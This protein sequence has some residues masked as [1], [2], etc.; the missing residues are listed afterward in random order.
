MKAFGL[1]PMDIH[2]NNKIWISTKALRCVST[3]VT[4]Q[5]WF[6]VLFKY[7]RFFAAMLT[8]SFPWVNAF[9]RVTYACVILTLFHFCFDK[10]KRFSYTD[11]HV[12]I[13][14]TG[15]AISYRIKNKL[16]FYENSRVATIFFSRI[17]L[18]FT[19]FMQFYLITI[20]R[21]TVFSFSCFHVTL[22]ICGRFPSA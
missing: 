3:L 11:S 15:C 18:F 7:W 4:S 2:G 12:I 14:V 13:H 10:N 21:H 17:V 19:N 5:T 16:I 20:W 22:S 9:L 1:I 8:F 6:H